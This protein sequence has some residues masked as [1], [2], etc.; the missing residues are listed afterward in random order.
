MGCIPQMPREKAP[1]GP[2]LYLRTQPNLAMGCFWPILPYCCCSLCSLTGI[3]SKAFFPCLPGQAPAQEPH[4]VQSVSEIVMEKAYPG[5]PCIGRERKFKQPLLEF[6]GACAG[7][8]E[9][10]YAKLI[11]QLFGDRMYT[12]WKVPLRS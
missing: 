2:T 6:H 3:I 8:G 9:T 10:P 12:L 11:T 5:N 1:P 4:P 7:C